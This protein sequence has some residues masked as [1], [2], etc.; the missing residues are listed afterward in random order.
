MML[1]CLLDKN[2]PSLLIYSIN[3]A[4]SPLRS[5]QFITHEVLQTQIRR[6]SVEK[7]SDKFISSKNSENGACNTSIINDIAACAFDPIEYFIQSTIVTVVEIF[8]LNPSVDALNKVIDNNFSKKV[9]VYIGIFMRIWALSL[10]I[11]NDLQI[12]C[13]YTNEEENNK[14][15][16]PSL[17]IMLTKNFKNS[18]GRDEIKKHIAEVALIVSDLQENN[19][20][21]FEN[22]NISKLKQGI[23]DRFVTNTNADAGEGNQLPLTERDLI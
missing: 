16:L 4:A 23:K 8:I 7:N 22:E 19:L 13:G 18:G 2:L 3:L 6:S 5:T 17:K 10:V 9:G 21:Y 20:H 1:I 11:N 12:I 14:K 15:G